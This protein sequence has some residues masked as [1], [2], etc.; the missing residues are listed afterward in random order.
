VRRW[1][2]VAK[3]EYRLRTSSF[4]KFRRYFPFAMVVLLVVLVGFVAPAVANAIMSRVDIP[5]FFISVAAL[6]M[7]QILL[8]FFFFY[9]MIFPISNTL[10][11]IDMQEYEIFLNAPIRPGDVLLGKFMGVFPFYAIVIVAVMGF[12]MAFLLPLGLDAIQIVILITTFV[13]T[14]LAGAWIGTVIAALLRSKLGRTARG[15]DIGKAIPLILAIPMIAVMYALMG[16]GLGEILTD[17]SSSGFVKDILIVFP[18]SWGA[19]LFVLF[20][21]NPGDITS[22]ALETLTRFGGLVLFFAATLWLGAKAA[23][24][25]YNVEMT[26]FTPSVAKADRTFYKTVKFLGGGQAFGTL[27]VSI[28]KDY[29][30]R[31][32][33]LSKLAYM[34]GLLIMIAVFFGDFEDAFGAIAIGIFLFPF[35]TVFVVG[36]VT[37][38]GKENL[39]IYR[40]APMGEGRY[41]WGRLV[42]GW[43]IV[44]P[45]AVVY[46]A[47]VVLL[48]PNIN[49]LTF[50][51]AV[52]FVFLYVAAAVV[53]ALGVFLMF[54]VFTDK[55]SELMLNAMVV[56]MVSMFLFIFVEILFG[57][58]WNLLI[59]VVIYWAIA[60]T[61]LSLGRKRLL[62]LE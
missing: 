12:F 17:P 49:A 5:A 9:F 30:R 10:K 25:A 7:M 11:D 62:S 54:P 16:G 24:R 38:R 20:A 59:M 23:N 31:F 44:M 28:F 42:Q 18:S 43:L 14:F 3:N 57:G 1:L 32:E 40:K 21:T 41:I 47:I 39:F 50:L 36:E 27:L 45:I 19:E 56:M 51:L 34:L 22:V 46:S 29:G 15:R 26:T 33:N 37:I 52:G 13:V 6:P 55:P 61:A 58:P 4:R 60:A 2:V 35:L 48:V 8:F 53:F